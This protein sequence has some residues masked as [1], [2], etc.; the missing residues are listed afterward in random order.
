MIGW[1]IFALIW[2]IVGVWSLEF[3]KG[4]LFNL[5]GLIF[6]WVGGVLHCFRARHSV[7][8]APVVGLGFYCG[9]ID[10]LELQVF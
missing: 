6:G 4:H 8:F 7:V 5:H 3:E 1:L 2:G 9:S 10:F